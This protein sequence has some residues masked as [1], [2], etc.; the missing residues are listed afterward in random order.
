MVFTPKS[1]LRHP[2][3]VSTVEELAEGSF[4]EVI[5]DAEARVAEVR[6][7]VFCTGKF[8]YDLLATREELGR[9]D[10]ALVRLEQLF[11]LPVEQMQ[12]IIGKYKKADDLVWAQEEP[13]NMGA[14]SHLMMHFPGAARFRVASRRIYASPAAG[15]PA[16]SR[17]RHQQVIDSVFD[18]SKDN[19]SRPKSVTEAAR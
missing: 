5:D 11:P 1:L 8:Y 17:M 2:K 10:V 15:S 3:C 13:R 12:A 18:K 14:W 9:K 6:S 7:L 16:R 19:T 4:Q